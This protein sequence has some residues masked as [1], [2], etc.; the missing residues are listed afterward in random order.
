MRVDLPPDLIR[1]TGEKLCHSSEPEVALVCP[2]L[3]PAFVFP[4]DSRLRFAGYSATAQGAGKPG[5][6][7]ARGRAGRPGSSALA[8]GRRRG[9]S[10]PRKANSYHSLSLTHFTKPEP[11]S[12]RIAHLSV[13]D[14]LAVGVT[15]KRSR[16]FVASVQKTRKALVGKRY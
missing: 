4:L 16:D 10:C 12:S 8:V 9:V 11:M 5:A 14:V 2:A 15:L 13:I 6:P 3:P 1:D 7:A